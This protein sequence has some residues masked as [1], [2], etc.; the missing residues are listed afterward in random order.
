MA[1]TCNP[2]YLG[3]RDQEDCGSRPS[4]AKSM[5]DPISTNGWARWHAAVIIL[6]MQGN[7]NRITVQA[8]PGIMRDLSQS[9]PDQKGL[10][11]WFKL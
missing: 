4:Q 3:V 2:S 7:T 1:H 10:G 6:A 8:S 11:A 9:Q 5:R